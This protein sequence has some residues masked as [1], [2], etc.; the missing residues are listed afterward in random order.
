MAR[1]RMRKTK[2]FDI[3]MLQTPNRRHQRSHALSSSA[4]YNELKCAIVVVRFGALTP[5][6]HLSG[7]LL[8]SDWSASVT[9]DIHKLII[10]TIGPRDAHRVPLRNLHGS[11]VRPDVRTAAPPPPHDAKCMQNT[12]IVKLPTVPLVKKQSCRCLY[13]TSPLT[14]R[15]MSSSSKAKGSF[16]RSRLDGGSR[17]R[18]SS[19]SSSS[20][21]KGSFSVCAIVACIAATIERALGFLG[22]AA[23]AAAASC[24]DGAFGSMERGR[25]SRSWLAAASSNASDEDERRATGWADLRAVGLSSLAAETAKLPSAPSSD[26]NAPELRAPMRIP[27]SSDENAPELRAPMRIPP[28]F[29]G[30]RVD[31]ADTFVAGGGIAGAGAGGIADAAGSGGCTSRAAIFRSLAAAIA[32]EASAFAL[33][34]ATAFALASDAALATELAMSSPAAAR[35][36]MGDGPVSLAAVESLSTCMGVTST[37]GFEGAR[38]R[39]GLGGSAESSLN[40][41]MSTTSFFDAFS[42]FAP[43]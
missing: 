37:E 40:A 30:A 39:T 12:R 2:S 17:L 11:G 26:E 38:G 8:D 16:L 28:S 19:S 9:N 10:G 41:K 35:G 34:C 33:A 29:D 22:T 32:L 20:K 27:P 42:G 3:D 13:A 21:A 31:G 1:K 4:S 15:Q 18:T 14:S 23:A 43:R 24:A 6:S 36:L 7:L 5:N 25:M